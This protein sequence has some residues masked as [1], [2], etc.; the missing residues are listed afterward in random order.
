[1]GL[2]QRC[3]RWLTP[4]VFINARL[5]QCTRGGRFFVRWMNQHHTSL[6]QWALGC[7]NLKSS[8][9][10][11]DIGC[12]GGKALAM[13]AKRAP[14]AELYGIDKSSQSVQI[15][16]SADRRLIERG[17]LQISEGDVS[18]LPYADDSFDTVTAFE[19]VYYWPNLVESFREV[20]RVLR[21][22]GKFLICN[23][24]ADPVKAAELLKLIPM[25]IYTAEELC[26]A[27][28]EAGFNRVWI[29]SEDKQGWICVI[30]PMVE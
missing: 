5:P 3:L 2:L 8:M 19:T 18:S 23:E 16:R 10:I 14:Q 24:D 20:R 11:L 9:S 25:R 26:Q 1:M 12:G 13:M 15:A 4:D 30:A 29:H 7:I 21:P 27:L 28:N 6:M 22:G 17:R